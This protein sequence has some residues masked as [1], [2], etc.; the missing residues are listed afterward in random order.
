MAETKWRSAGEGKVW[1]PA[2]GYLCCLAPPYLHAGSCISTVF[3]AYLLVHGVSGASDS[4]RKYP[5]RHAHTD[6]P[7][8]VAWLK[9]GQP[10]H[11]PSV[12]GLNWPTGQ[13]EEDTKGK[14]MKANWSSYSGHDLWIQHW[15]KSPHPRCLRQTWLKLNL[16]IHF[17]GFFSGYF[18]ARW[19]QIDRQ[20][21]VM[22]AINWRQSQ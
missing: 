10:V 4:A 15:T 14:Q 11:C 22:R 2:S 8:M 9:P 18:G 3:L 16:Q 12:P 5:E 6:A 19:L 13:A 20:I 1:K 7:L 21:H 17:W